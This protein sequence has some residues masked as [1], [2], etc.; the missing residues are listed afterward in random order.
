VVPGESSGTLPSIL[1]RLADLLERQAQVRSKVMS[2][3][4]YPVVLAIVATF[5][6]S[7]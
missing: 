7:P 1:A 2:A 6:V 5:V 4:A 3:L